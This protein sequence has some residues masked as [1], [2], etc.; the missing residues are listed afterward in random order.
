VSTVMLALFQPQ[1][2]VE[3]TTRYKPLGSGAPIVNTV[4]RPNNHVPSSEHGGLA[5]TRVHATASSSSSNLSAASISARALAGSSKNKKEKKFSSPFF[6]VLGR[7]HITMSRHQPERF[8]K[9]QRANNQLRAEL[10]IE[11]IKVS[12]AATE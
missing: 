11:R 4:T 2:C 7:R 1:L 8:D 5:C 6:C 12:E 10:A 9:L 3:H